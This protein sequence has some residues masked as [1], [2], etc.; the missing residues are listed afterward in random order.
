MTEYTCTSIPDV[1][2]TF[3]LLLIRKEWLSYFFNSDAKR[4][5]NAIN[6]ILKRIKF[7]NC[8]NNNSSHKISIP[9]DFSKIVYVCLQLY[10]LSK[11]QFRVFL[12]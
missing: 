11:N 6:N 12:I 1:K 4:A 3:I 7:M 5:G 10:L 8:M 9:I 2:K